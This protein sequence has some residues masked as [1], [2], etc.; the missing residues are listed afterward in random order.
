MKIQTIRNHYGWVVVLGFATALILGTVGFALASSH[1]TSPDPFTTA[2]LS[3]NWEG[4][5][6]FPTGG[7][8]SVSE[9]GRDEVALIGIDSS[10]TASGGFYRTEGIKTVGVQN[11]GTAVEVDLYLDPDWEDKAVRAGFW[12]VGDDGAGTRDNL[13]GIIEFVNSEDCD[14]EEDCSTHPTNR[15]DHEGFRIWDSNIG[16]T[17]ELDT[18]FEYG[19]WVTLG[20]ELNT[21]TEKYIYYINGEEVGTATGG[22]EFIRELFLNSYN[23]GLD[24]F[25]NLSSDSYSTH[26]HAGLLDPETKDDCKKGDWEDFGF[27]NQGL[28]IQFVNTGKDSR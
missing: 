10:L 26:W 6:T 3:T 28:C 25:P 17:E 12:V 13:F 20:I 5:R 9:F 2:E 8:T 19:E 7:V 4:D 16:W 18:D 14:A 21:V 11:F 23:Y 1:F 15:P 24:T 27:R 22:T